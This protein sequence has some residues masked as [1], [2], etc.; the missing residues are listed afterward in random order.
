MEEKDI[1]WKDRKHIGLVPGPFTKYY[2]ADSRLIIETG[3]LKTVIEETLLYR[4]VDITMEQ[5]LFRKMFGTGTLRLKTRVDDT[6]EIIL[7][8][9]IDPRE[10]RDLIS[11]LVEESR[12]SQKIIGKEFYGE[13]CECKI[14]HHHS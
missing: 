11:K 14:I 8:D 12:Q 1:L 9:I 7:Q 10:T 3:F 2:I 6:P 13:D 4:I 5:P